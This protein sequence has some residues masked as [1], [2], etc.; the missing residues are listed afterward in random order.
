MLMLLLVF[1][2]VS[3]V[4]QGSLQLARYLRITSDEYLSQ[5]TECWNYR[6]QQLFRE[7]DRLSLKTRLFEHLVLALPAEGGTVPQAGDPFLQPCL[8]RT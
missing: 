4:A 6:Q 5:C 3:Y 8:F 7:L 2:I 1:E